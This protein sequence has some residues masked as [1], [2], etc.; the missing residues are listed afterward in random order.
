MTLT[1]WFFLKG[2]RSSDYLL[3]SVRDNSTNIL[4]VY[5]NL[6]N[7]FVSY[8][9]LDNTNTHS[10]CLFV[11]NSWHYIKT[12][13]TFDTSSSTLS[14]VFQFVSGTNTLSSFVDSSA[15][16]KAGLPNEFNRFKMQV[17][18]GN[19]PIIGEFPTCTMVRYVRNK[20]KISN[21]MMRY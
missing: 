5:Y 14:L 20:L 17:I 11:K 7:S 19:N 1:G 3:F 6:A 18:F 15:I 4:T 13:L 2:T 21:Y 9:L 12:K 16:L 8:D 10:S